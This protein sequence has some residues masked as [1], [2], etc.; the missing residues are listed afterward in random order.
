VQPSQPASQAHQRGSQ[1]APALILKENGQ[2]IV[3]CQHAN[4][5]TGQAKQVEQ[6]YQ[7]LVLPGRRS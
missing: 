6:R 4:E 1:T 7:L 2:K 3:G 5:H